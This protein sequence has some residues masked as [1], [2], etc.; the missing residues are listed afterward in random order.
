MPTTVSTNRL[1]LFRANEY[2]A[3]IRTL[4]FYWLMVGETRTLNFQL[5]WGRDADEG[6]TLKNLKIGVSKYSDRREGGSEVVNGGWI[7]VNSVALTETATRTLTDIPTDSYADLQITV[8]VPSGAQTRG[9]AV[10]RMRF[11]SEDETFFYGDDFCGRNLYSIKNTGDNNGI[12]TSAE[13]VFQFFVL[14][15]VTAQ[16]FENA[17]FALSATGGE[18]TIPLGGGGSSG[19]SR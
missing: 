8:A 14:D 4:P 7:S 6:D 15:R 18:R 11:L 17:G 9:Y 16:A 3:E 12:N 2:D 5:W 19:R 10:C 1:Q 13:V